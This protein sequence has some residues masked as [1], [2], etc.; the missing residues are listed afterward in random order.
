MIKSTAKNYVLGQ[1]WGGL[2][3]NLQYSNLPKLFMVKYGML[4]CFNV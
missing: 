1:P 4:W 2:G 3:D